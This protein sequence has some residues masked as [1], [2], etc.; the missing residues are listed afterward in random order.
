[1]LYI[2]WRIIANHGK[3]PRKQGV[4]ALGAGDHSRTPLFVQGSGTTV[5]FQSGSAPGVPFLVRAPP[6]PASSTRLNLVSGSVL[7]GRK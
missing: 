1:M 7:L 4:G 3:G 6:P 2:W 5:K